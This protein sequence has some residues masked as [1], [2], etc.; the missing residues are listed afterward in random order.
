MKFLRVLL[1]LVSTVFADEATVVKIFDGDTIQVNNGGTIQ[2]IRFLGID[3]PETRI[4]EKLSNDSKRTKQSTEK[5]IALGNKSKA[6]LESILSVGDKVRL[7]YD[8]NLYQGNRLLAYVYKDSGDML[9]L[10]LIESGFATTMTIPPNVKYA[11][12]FKKAEN[13][14]R[15]ERKG[16]WNEQ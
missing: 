3:T 2:T 7:E 12:T 13:L 15:K 14:A 8:L 16:N 6:Y 1:L 10:K 5:I 9:N 11:D 4:N